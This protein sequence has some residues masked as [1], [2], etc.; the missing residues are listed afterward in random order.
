MIVNNASYIKR[1]EA[2]L[3]IYNLNNGSNYTFE[4]VQ[5]KF[6]DIRELKK[7]IDNDNNFIPSECMCDHKIY[8]EYEIINPDNGDTLILGSSCIETYMIKSLSKCKKC[9][10]RFKFKPNSKNRCNDCKKVKAKCKRCNK[11]KKVRKIKKKDFLNCKKCI[12]DLEELKLIELENK[13]KCKNCN[14]KINGE[15]YKRCYDCNL[16]YKNFYK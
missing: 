10:K 15:K 7:R 6:I 1:F 4:D 13:N 11:I 5:N 8:K 2:N 9:N 3:E 14:K 16:F 12:K